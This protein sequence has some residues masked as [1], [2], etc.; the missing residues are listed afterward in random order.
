VNDGVRADVI[1]LEAGLRALLHS[2]R[3]ARVTAVNNHGLFVPLPASFGDNGYEGL[4]G[5]SAIDLVE[6]DQRALVIDAWDRVRSAGAG[7]ARVRLSRGD[8]ALLYFF[9]LREKHDVLV[10][11][12]VPEND[13]EI[14]HNRDAVE[15]A[16]RVSVQRKN[17]SAIFLD[18]DEAT[19]K[20]LGWPRDE[21]VGHGSLE[22]VHPDDRD[23]AIES[24]MDMLSSAGGQRRARLRYRHANGKWIWLEL[25]N[26]NLLDDTEH[27]CV[28]TEALDVSDEMAAHEAVQFREQLLRRVAETVPLG[29]VQVDRT[30]EILYA[31]ERLY[32][33]LGVPKSGLSMKPFAQLLPDD[34]TELALALDGLLIDGIDRDL[35][36]AVRTRRPGTDRRCLLRLRAL[37]DGDGEVGGAIVCVEDVT[38]RANARAEL[39]RRATYDPLT[40]ALNRASVL[41]RLEVQLSTSGALGVIFIDLDGFKAVNDQFGHS[42]GDKLLVEVVHRVQENIRGS[43]A[44]G[45]FGG[46]EFLVVCPDGDLV[47][48][49]QVA[50]R[51][52]TALADPVSFADGTISIRA[53]IGITTSNDSA[54]SAESLIA[55]ADTAMYVAKR[56]GNGRPV[57]YDPLE[58]AR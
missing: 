15:V 46:D 31:N 4:H 56:N 21:I 54:A 35:E 57:A 5:R 16:P 20:M 32:E 52:T 58:H 49:M 48:L 37:T 10:C 9:D 43:D 26:H 45:R 23:R 39:E 8:E 14:E 42:A 41:Q 51:I 38:D 44:L 22:F 25:T 24:W 1:A 29:L 19:T 13:T 55:D 53:S 2:N 40:G 11:V 18:V 7:Q 3:R 30:G 36:V 27:P 28:V 12:L 33:I 47:A 17:E 50:S 34:R 6:P